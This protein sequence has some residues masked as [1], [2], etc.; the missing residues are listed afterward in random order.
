MERLLADAR[1]AARADALVVA[2][3]E[4][5]TGKGAL[6]KQIHLWSPRARFPFVNINCAGLSKELLESE[7][8]GHERGAFTGAGQAKPGLFEVAHRGTLFLD[9]VAEIDLALQ[10]RLLKAIEEKTFHRVG[11]VTERSVDCRVIAATNRDL[12]AEVAASRFRADFYYR[13]NVLSLKLPALRDR[14]GDIPL[15][16]AKFLAEFDARAGRRGRRFGAPAERMLAAY[17]WPGNVRELRNLA[18]RLS[19]LSRAETI[20]PAGVARFLGIPGDSG[21]RLRTLEEKEREYIDEVLRLTG[22]NKSAAA[23]I[24]GITRNTLYARVR[25]G[26]PEDEAMDSS[27]EP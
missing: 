11:G 10:P 6:A 8:F 26:M 19:I 24:L 15:L 5:G 22:G 27:E 16:A 3:G 14:P 23:E 21:S 4:S 12:A 9:E 2:S 17:A 13:L 25:P 1:D 7:L 20:D 18:E